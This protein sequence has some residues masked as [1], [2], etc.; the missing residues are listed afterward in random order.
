MSETDEVSLLKIFEYFASLFGKEWRSIVGITV[1][2]VLVGLIIIFSIPAKYDATTTFV[3][4]EPKPSPMSGLATNPLLSGFLGSGQQLSSTDLLMTILK[5]ESVRLEV[6]QNETVRRFV[7]KSIGREPGSLEALDENGKFYAIDFLS[8]VVNVRN[9]PK[10]PI[11]VSVRTRDP[12]ISAILA[13]EYVAAVRRI[14]SS[15]VASKALRKRV[16]V[17]DLLEDRKARAE[18]IQIQLMNFDQNG[19]IK[20]LDSQMLPMLEKLSELIRKEANLSLYLDFITK[21][22]P[23]DSEAKSHALNQLKKLRS[24]KGNYIKELDAGK[25]GTSSIETRPIEKLSI[26]GIQ[27]YVLSTQA[28]AMDEV[29]TFLSKEL[30]MAKIQEARDEINMQ[31]LDEARMDSIPDSPRRFRLLVVW[32]LLSF[33]ISIVFCGTRNF[34]QQLYSNFKRA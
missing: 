15:K 27:Y 3:P 24:E 34:R 6:M 20:N 23:S 19:R 11:E 31:V 5:S 21:F 25:F 28:R 32:M 1:G 30:E 17:S 18:E 26:L 12:E 16:F 8:Q 33:C 14:M 7:M 29:I 13:T 4:D 2:L 9:N 10:G 22:G